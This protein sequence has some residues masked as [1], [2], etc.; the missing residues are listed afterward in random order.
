MKNIMKEQIINL[1]ETHKYAATDGLFLSGYNNGE[2]IQ[3]FTNWNLY[4]HCFFDETNNY[5][6]EFIKYRT[7][8]KISSHKFYSK[9]GPE[10]FGEEIAEYHKPR[11]KKEYP[12]G[13][14]I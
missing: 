11:L 7:D 5:I 6:G 8:G 9:G 1:F 3:W 10:D 4:V 12:K 13:P 2:F 14:W